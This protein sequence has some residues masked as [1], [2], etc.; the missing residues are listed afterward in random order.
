MPSERIFSV[1]G[2]GKSIFFYLINFFSTEDRDLRGPDLGRRLGVDR[3]KL[4]GGG[5]LGRLRGEGGKGVWVG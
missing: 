1:S 5:W 3:R 4:M 2:G